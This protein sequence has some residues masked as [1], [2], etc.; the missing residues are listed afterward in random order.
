MGRLSARLTGTSAPAHAGGKRLRAA[1]PGAASAAQG[2]RELLE[3]AAL[4]VA[5]VLARL[6]SS[7][8]GLSPEQVEERSSGSGPTTS[9]TRESK[10]SWARSWNAPGTRSSSSSS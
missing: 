8:K 4:P 9:S 5:N 6:G 2:E 1:D 3:C 10:A 7:D